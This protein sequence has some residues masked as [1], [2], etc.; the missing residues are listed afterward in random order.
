MANQ[1]YQDESTIFRQ[2]ISIR[3]W[4]DSVSNSGISSA[5]GSP[6]LVDGLI[7]LRFAGVSQDHDHYNM[8]SYWA[9]HVTMVVNPMI[10]FIYVYICTDYIH[11]CMHTYIPTYLHT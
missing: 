10:I 1:H 11:A 7:N 4:L 9:Y 8:I 6:L 5:P 3:L 2:T